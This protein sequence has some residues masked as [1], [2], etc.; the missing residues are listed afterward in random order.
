MLHIDLKV[1]NIR[2]EFFTM[3]PLTG[4][5]MVNRVI[6]HTNI[7]AAVLSG[8]A[9][10]RRLVGFD[11]FDNHNRQ[12]GFDEIRDVYANWRVDR[13]AQRVAGATK[14]GVTCN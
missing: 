6:H 10:T 9:V 4:V 7:P 5:R 11:I 3:D 1:H 2:V 14:D 12:V 13:T 8:I